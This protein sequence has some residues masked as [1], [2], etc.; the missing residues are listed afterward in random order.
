MLCISWMYYGYRGFG[1]LPKLVNLKFH[2]R[3]RQ[4][5][6]HRV[7]LH[8]Y[9]SFCTSS[10]FRTS[11][12][13][14]YL[15]ILIGWDFPPILITELP[16]LRFFSFVGLLALLYIITYNLYS[17]CLHVS[18]LPQF[19]KGDRNERMQH[20]LPELPAQELSAALVQMQ[21]CINNSKFGYCLA[22][23]VCSVHIPWWLSQIV[24]NL[25]PTPL[26][27]IKLL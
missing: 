9:R 12:G 8:S 22:N 7:Q 14:S 3:H 5:H 6:E 10:I 21:S 20:R 13:K 16:D 17:S 26:I 19:G 2:L 11:T 24:D 15:R 27:V 23:I 4:Y 18:C 25:T 1:L